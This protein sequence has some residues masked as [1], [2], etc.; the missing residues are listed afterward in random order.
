[1]D[2]YVGEIRVFSCNYAPEGWA[3]CA[4][5][6][7]PISQNTALFSLLGIQYG[8]DGKLTFALPNLM[9]MV[10]IHQGQGPGLSDRTIG[11]TGG[12]ENVTL[13]QQQVPAHTHPAQCNAG[14]GNKGNPAGAYWAAD[15][16]AAYEYG[17]TPNTTM[18]AIAAAGGGQAH[19]NMMPY[20]T[21]LYCIALTGEYPP[22]S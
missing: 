15:A 13:N 10:P 19:T 11:E 7:L 6:I 1:M 16:G 5:Q 20:T 2:Q 9:G 8:G 12:V 21:V 4:G 3:I 17:A 18:A 14:A 22:H